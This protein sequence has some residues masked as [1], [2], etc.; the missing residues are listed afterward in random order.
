MYKYFIG[1]A[2]MNNSNALIMGNVT[3]KLEKQITSDEDIKEVEKLIKTDLIKL[4]KI[5]SLAFRTANIVVI[6]FQLLSS[7]NKPKAK[8]ERK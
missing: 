8:R 1:Y 3:I 2:V 4:N 5:G 7:L 6:N